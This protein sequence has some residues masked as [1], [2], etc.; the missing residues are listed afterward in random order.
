LTDEQIE[1]VH[2]VIQSLPDSVKVM[3]ETIAGNGEALRFAQQFQDTAVQ[4]GKSGNPKAVILG[5]TWRQVPVGLWIVSRSDDG[6][7]GPYRAQLT[8]ALSSKDIP[9]KLAGAI[10]W[11]T[12]NSISS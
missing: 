10:G 5:I 9:F 3:V 6:P 4:C 1:A 2:K 7:V 11:R 12:K 8:Q